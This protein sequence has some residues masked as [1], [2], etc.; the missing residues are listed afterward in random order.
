M[1]LNRS[2]LNLQFPNVA[3]LNAV[4]RRNMQMQAKERKWAQKS[5]NASPQK[6]AK[7]SKRAQKSTKRELPRKNC[8]QPGLEQPGLTLNPPAQSQ[9]M[10]EK[11][12]GELIF[13]RIHAGPVFALARI[14]ENIFEDVFPEYF[15]KFLGE[16]TR[17]KYMPCLYS[18]LGEYRKFS[19]QMI[20]VLVSC[21]GVIDLLAN[22][23]S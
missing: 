12:L 10:Q 14:Q 16:F 5:A 8:K 3:A 21:Q 17:C 13:V 20:Y 19:W 4:G 11:N 9:Y 18:H 15:A 1:I 6:S 23:D 22:R 2:D 7:E